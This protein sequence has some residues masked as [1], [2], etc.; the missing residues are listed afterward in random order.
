MKIYES[1]ADWEKELRLLSGLGN[2][3][4]ADHAL[5]GAV[6]FGAGIVNAFTQPG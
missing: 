4:E 6:L 3:N 5:R 2:E 1:P